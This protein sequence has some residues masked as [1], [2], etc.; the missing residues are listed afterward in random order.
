MEVM[1]HAWYYEG[2]AVNVYT[3]DDGE[4]T[5]VLATGCGS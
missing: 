1:V 2:A 5:E 3:Y 4:L